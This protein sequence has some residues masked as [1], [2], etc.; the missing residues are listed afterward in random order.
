MRAIAADFRPRQQHL[1]SEV[2]FDLFAQAL[3]RLA[4]KLFHLAAAQADHVRV[5]LLQAGLI[6]MLIAAVV[7]EVQFVHQTAGLEHFQRAIHGDP[8]EL[9][10]FLLR[11]LEQALGIQMLAGLIDQF[12]QYLALAREANAPLLQRSFS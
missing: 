4:E 11:H 8:V 3:Q 1:K 10:V 5:L 9:R 2:A 6:I 12:K 7:H